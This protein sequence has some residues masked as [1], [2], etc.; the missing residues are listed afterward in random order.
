VTDWDE[1]LDCCLMALALDAGLEL[2]P[3]D[4][5]HSLALYARAGCTL[6]EAAAGCRFTEKQ[7]PC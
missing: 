5:A 4:C 3:Q 6:R 2:V 1:I 7:Q